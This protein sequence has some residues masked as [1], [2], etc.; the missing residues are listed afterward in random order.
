MK[1]TSG[2]LFWPLGGLLKL[3]AFGK[4][5]RIVH[6]DPITGP[7]ITLSNHTSFYDFIY[8]TTALYPK[9]MNYLAAH[10]MFFDPLLGPFLRL[11]RAIP[12]ALLQPDAVA[13]MKALR[14][15]K[16]K[17]IL[18]IFPEGQISP[19]GRF[20][21]PTFSVAKLIKKAKV[22]VFI[23]KHQFPY[24]VNP[25]WTKKTFRG[26]MDT[27]VVKL[28]DR[29]D[30]PNLSE[31]EIY[32]SVYKALYHSPYE[33]NLLKQY[34]Y[35]L[36]DIQGLEHVLTECPTC[37]KTGL[38]SQKH[39][40]NCPHCQ[41]IFKYDAYGRIDNQG[42]D[43]YYEAQRQ[44]LIQTVLA[45]PNYTLES[46]VRLEGYRNKRVQTIGEGHLTLSKDGYHFVGKVFNEDKTYHFDVKDVPTCP[47]DI[48]RNIQIYEGYELYQFVFENPYLPTQFVLLGEVLHDLYVNKQLGGNQ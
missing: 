23:V 8:T 37:H 24:L 25:P 11:S 42:V 27:Q 6:K 16:N 21:K 4:G 7:A 41:A 22:D 3:Y 39:Q 10:K 47:S 15:L 38:V 26:R 1:K 46:P 28:F 13:T 14:V 32:E 48:G 34:T 45:N 29:N 20:M 43:V 2:T 40:L 9:R 18:S 33:D 12:K 36:N 5:Q 31:Q 19:S 30:I 44:R 17:G 35:K